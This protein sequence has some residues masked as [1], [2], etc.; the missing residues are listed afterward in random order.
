MCVFVLYEQQPPLPTPHPWCSP[1]SFLLHPQYVGTVST[2]NSGGTDAILAC[3]KAV[4][5][6]GKSFVVYVK[7]LFYNYALGRE[8]THKHKS[9]FKV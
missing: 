4:L 5:V 6:C 7:P 8:G 3:I 9:R 1:R 2:T